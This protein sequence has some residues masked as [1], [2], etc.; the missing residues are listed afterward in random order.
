MDCATCNKVGSVHR[1]YVCTVCM[2]STALGKGREGRGKEGGEQRDLR[3]VSSVREGKCGVVVFVAVVAILGG[4]R[5][6]KRVEKEEQR[7]GKGARR[8]REG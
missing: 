8:G 3:W 6:W 5:C 1:M 4:G 2:Y 7:G